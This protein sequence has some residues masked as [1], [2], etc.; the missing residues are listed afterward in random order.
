MS[1]IRSMAHRIISSAPLLFSP[2]PR[3]NLEPLPPVRPFY[4]ARTS[5]SCARP[6]RGVCGT[7][8]VPTLGA[9]HEHGGAG[10][11][12]GST[13]GRDVPQWTPIAPCL[14]HPLRYRLTG[15]TARARWCLRRNRRYGRAR[16]GRHGRTSRP[17][18]IWHFAPIEVRRTAL[19]KS[20]AVAPASHPGKTSAAQSSH[21]DVRPA[22]PRS[23]GVPCRTRRT[24]RYGRTQ[25]RYGP[26]HLQTRPPISFATQTSAVTRMS[27][28]LQSRVSAPRR[29]TKDPS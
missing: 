12:P 6:Q 5:P 13:S 4:G 8:R 26:P 18:L 10:C 3:Q 20:S 16:R 14:S 2:S 25:P 21:L 27:S 28:Y 15:R 11:G 29:A 22:T 9:A 19:S 23:C 7:G 17:R 24:S 1:Q